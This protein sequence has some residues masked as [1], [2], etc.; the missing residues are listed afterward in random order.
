[1]LA[2]VANFNPFAA[3]A[4]EV[5]QRGVQVQRVA[6][7]VEIGHFDV[8]ALADLAA[9]GL[10]LAQD[11]FQQRGFARAVGAEQADFVAPQQ[12]GAE[13]LDDDFAGTIGVWK[14]FADIGQLGHQLAAGRA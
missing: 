3:G 13:V 8:G 4:D 9:V 10:N 6:H 2:F 14:A 7:L 1:M 5:F 11:E 12:G